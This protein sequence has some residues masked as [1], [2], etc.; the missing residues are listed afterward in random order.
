MAEQSLVRAHSDPGAVNLPATCLPSELPGELTDL[1]NG[2]RWHRLSEGSEPTAGID[3]DSTTNGC[4][5]SPQERLGL[6]LSTQ[7]Q[8]LVPVKF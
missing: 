4:L 3:R 6:A 1:G 7:A 5:T 8:L 2:L